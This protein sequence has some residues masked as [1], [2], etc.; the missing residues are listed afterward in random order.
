MKITIICD[1]IEDAIQTL[2][3]IDGDLPVECQTMEPG[4]IV[5]F[6]WGEIEL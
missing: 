3:S 5:Y 6:P 2:D 4:K 1:S